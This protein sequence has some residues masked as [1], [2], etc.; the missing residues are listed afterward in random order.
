LEH[1]FILAPHIFVFASLCIDP[2]TC[3]ENFQN[4]QMCE[5]FSSATCSSRLNPPFAKG[6]LLVRA[7][8]RFGWPSR[9]HTKNLRQIMYASRL[10]HRLCAHESEATLAGSPTVVGACRTCA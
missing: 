8:S 2:G 7:K 4:F 5:T 3:S 1:V 10:R 6:Y 9:Y